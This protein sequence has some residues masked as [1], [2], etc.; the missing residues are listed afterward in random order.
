MDVGLVSHRCLSACPAD[1]RKRR[2][3]ACMQ[4]CAHR[5]TTCSCMC[6]H[7]QEKSS[8]RQTAKMLQKVG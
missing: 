3:R 7:A 5:H 1:R 8:W 4:E 2:S 6:M